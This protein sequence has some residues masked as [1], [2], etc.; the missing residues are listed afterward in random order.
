M[1]LHEI[2][3]V[4]SSIQRES[5]SHKFRRSG[6]KQKTLIIEFVND[7]VQTLGGRYSLAPSDL[8]ADDWYYVR[9]L[10]PNDSTLF[11]GVFV[12]RE[13]GLYIIHA[14]LLYPISSSLAFSTAEKYL[15]V[16]HTQSLALAKCVEITK[17]SQKPHPV[18]FRRNAW[19]NTGLTVCLSGS[20]MDN[21]G[22]L[23]ALSIDDI[24]AEDWQ[25]VVLVPREN[26]SSGTFVIHDGV[27][28]LVFDGQMYPAS[29]ALPLEEQKVLLINDDEGDH[30]SFIERTRHPL[31][32]PDGVT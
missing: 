23:I 15:V 8:V 2:I 12:I 28:F 20:I 29:R 9:E 16:D 7:V 18:R 14:A 21:N 5:G 6:W 17:Q 30:R 24:F 32:L 13:D 31:N 25:R 26:I 3:E 11:N 10:P 27:K 19:P 1:K 22:K 4:S